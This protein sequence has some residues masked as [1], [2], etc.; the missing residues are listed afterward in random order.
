MDSETASSLPFAPEMAGRASVL[1]PLA[2]F[3]AYD[4]ALPD[5]GLTPPPG[6][7][8]R[9]PLG[10]RSVTGVVWGDGDARIDATKL[11]QI[12]AALPVPALP[13]ISRRFIDWVAAYN[14]APLGSVLRM[15]MSVPDALEPERETKAW[16]IGGGFTGVTHR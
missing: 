4:Y 2:L 1:I 3:T 12:E 13:E 14:M 8:V 11:K 7:F 16:T 10:R 5:T 6:A 9:V 15:A